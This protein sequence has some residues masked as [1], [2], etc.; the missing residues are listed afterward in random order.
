MSERPTHIRKTQGGH[1][2][3]RP[4]RVLGEVILLVV[5]YV[6]WIA[7]TAAGTAL[8]MWGAVVLLLLIAPSNIWG[9]LALG[10]GAALAGGIGGAIVGFG[11][12]LALRRWLDGAASLGSFFSTILASSSALAAATTAGWWVYTSAGDLPGVLSG[13]AVYG[14]VFGLIQRPMLDYMSGRS[15]LWIPANAV[16]SLLGAITVLA[17]F[18]VSGGRRDMLQFRYAGIA[19]AVVVGAA[20]LWLTRETR[21]AVASRPPS[22]R[23]TAEGY[24]AEGYMAEGYMAEGYMAAERAGQQVHRE[25]PGTATDPMR[26]P[27]DAAIPDPAL[28]EIHEH[29]VYRVY[30]VPQD[31]DRDPAGGADSARDLP[32]PGDSGSQDRNNGPDVIDATYR[33]IS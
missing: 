13:V 4:R 7:C 31:L 16:A 30:P 12:V 3:R 9:Y 11:Q 32:H 20:F 10:L 1:T 5:R 26:M 14:C 33:V 18:D 22:Q 25:A 19:Y 24:M 15:I 29:R 21:R 28:L 8:N 6:L 17:A 27:R 2:P 23:H